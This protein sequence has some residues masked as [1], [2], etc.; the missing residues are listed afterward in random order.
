MP[1]QPAT[2]AGPTLPGRV[3]VGAAYY[4][5]YQPHERLDADLDLM[6]AGGFSVIRV[7][8][9]V[10]STWEPRDGDF[11]L[12]W[13]QPVLD[14]AHARGIRV[15]VGTPTYAVPPWLRQ[16]YPETT[17][18]V[19]TGAP[20]P[21]G[22]RQDV[23]YA[24][25]TFRRLAERVVRAVVGRYAGHPAVIGWQV[26]NEPGNKIFF[27]PDVF[28]GFVAS[29]RA[30][31]GTPAELNRAWGLTYWSHRIDDWSQLWTPDL[32]TT[33]AYDLAWRRYQAGLAD[34]L[35]RW[36]ADVVREYARPDQFVLTCIAPHHKAQ[37]VTTIAR[38]LDVA[39]V[40]IYYNTQD[41]LELPG[42]DGLVGGIAPDFVPWGGP[43]FPALQADIA[44]GVKDAPF[45]VTE[46]NATS[47][48]GSADNKP[49]YD[50]QLRQAA[51]LM[52]ARG[53]RL[54][55]YWHWHT[56]HY[57]A[58]TY[59][60]GI[61]GHS[62][63][64]GRA[65][66]ELS[67][68]ARELASAE[69][70]LAGLRPH[71]DV[72]LLVSPESRWA[73][74][75][76]GPLAGATHSWFGDPTSF[77]RIL[78]A[79]Y[80]G[81]FDAG[82]AVDVVGPNQLPDDPAALVARW[83]VLVVVGMIVADDATLDLLVRYAEAGG[84]LVLT[85]RTGYADALNVV[86]PVVAPGVLRAPAGVHYLEYTNLDRDVPVTGQGWAG[87][88]HAWADGLLPDDAEVLA[89]YD[90]PH[91]GRFAAVTTRAHGAGRVTT[92]GTVP[93]RALGRSLGRYLAGASLPVDPWRDARPASVTVHT[94][95]NGAGRRLRVVHNWSWEP[96][97]LTLPTDV[98][99]ALARGQLAAGAALELGGWD[100][101]VLLE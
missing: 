13:L 24:H 40:N 83:P 60:G 53:A 16:G 67:G 44:R 49:A 12:D 5:E 75:F 14:G 81:L 62:L 82:L 88:A 23:D 11:E 22:A 54:F 15:I 64:P 70:A 20:I 7:G 73:M 87:A 37:D 90:H 77:E 99:D 61:L 97:A 10:W 48:A 92:V 68:L 98:E 38:T 57:G 80:R 36:Q 65:Y 95:T 42:P 17:A 30:Q 27:N 29:L 56:L 4:H 69:D 72:A 89:G 33:P 71:T 96:V 45:L 94:A 1:E 34:E 63:T 41:A 101:R 76:Q 43:A 32:N 52:V 93:D 86:R 31:Y 59:W 39:G 28:E 2:A 26:D 78:A 84:H 35:I 66:H 47:V 19:A 21:Y 6:V 46:T 51:W 18:H 8:E 55:E 79:Y 3:L 58:E 85:P 9:S 25:P 50:G 100:V 91:L 74:E